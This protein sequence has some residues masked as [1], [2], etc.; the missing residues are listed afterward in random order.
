[1][2][3]LNCLLLPFL[4]V[5]AKRRYKELVKKGAHIS[6]N[7]ILKNLN[8]RDTHDINRKINPLL[9]A[10]DAIL[11]DNSDLSLKDQNILIENLINNK[12]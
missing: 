9:Q 6:F 8:D 1:M 12:T 5:R 11:I 3:N 7:D 10:E 2:Q 4:E